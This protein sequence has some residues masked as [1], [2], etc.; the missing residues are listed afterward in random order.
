MATLRERFRDWRGPSKSELASTLAAANAELASGR[1]TRFNPVPSGVP[2]SYNQF[3]YEQT[4]ALKGAGKW[5]KY[6]QMAQDPHI[7]GVLRNITLPLVNAD[8]E[9]EPASDSPRDEEIAEFVGANLLRAGGD[10]YGSEYYIQTPW[11]ATRLREVLD[12]LES[13]FSM[14]SKST[15][16]VK[17]KRI[18]DRL[19]WLEP[20]SVDPSGWVLDDTDR[21]TSVKRTY[22]TPENHF[23]FWEDLP[24]EQIVLYVWDMKGARYE[25]CPITRSMFGAWTRKEFKQKMS[26]ILA[27][28]LGAPVPY[29]FYP[30]NFPS[31]AIPAFRQFIESLRGTAAAEAYFMGPMGDDNTP[32]DIG[33]AGA[34]HNIDRGFTDIIDAEN[35]E[36][37][38]AGGN[39]TA[40]LG[41]TE[42]GSRSLGDSKGMMEMVLV[43]AVAE[44]VGE[45]ETH[46]MA[47]LPGPIEELVDWN[48]AGVK[49]YPRLV[50]G[51]INPFAI[52]SGWEQLVKAWDSG[53]I[54]K[55]AESRRQIVETH[56][57]LNL[58]DDAYEVEEPPL[59]PPV[60]PQALPA[61]GTPP[62]S[63]GDK[64]T[65]DGGITQE[66]MGLESAAD[67]KQ[68][69]AHMLVPV[70][71]APTGGNFR[72]GRNQLEVDVVNMAAVAGSFRVGERDFLIELRAAHRMMID[73]LMA[74]W[75]AGKIT[76]RNIEGQ[77]RSAFKQARKVR[78]ALVRVFGRVGAEG[79]GAVVDEI[80]RQSA[81]RD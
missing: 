51:Q 29:G 31:N 25:G 76:P 42:S 65:G 81:S 56:L 47:M 54:P 59:I 49:D 53:I 28:K 26:A 33:Y 11:K 68:R 41:E 66:R 50:A 32:P 24:A 43:E 14:F 71:D 40:N 77:R 69:L 10:K 38:H 39:T 60:P 23:K 1:F 64:D 27:Q 46:G 2:I 57:G 18:Y 7:R 6:D 61:N 79:W 52:Q 12:M 15:K 55:N 16:I 36:I 17:G 44:I 73:D 72:R 62:S 3:Q 35:R 8:W 22:S 48:F 45:F 21:L 70:E 78:A 37:G 74:R 67:F 80:G 75:R 13:G 30:K 19:Q 9:I 4:A 20:S 5:D 34:E 58:N 63:R